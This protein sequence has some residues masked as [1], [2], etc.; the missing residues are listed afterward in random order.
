LGT[1][2]QQEIHGALDPKLP[3]FLRCVQQRRSQLETLAGTI[4][5][6]FHVAV[7]G[8]VVA[9]QPTES[10]LGDREAE[11]CIVAAAQAVHFPR[12]HGGDVDLSWP[13]EIPLD[14]DVRAPVELDADVA[15]SV[16]QAKGDALLAQCGGAGPLVVTAYVDPDGR[17]LAAG[18]ATPDPTTAQRLDC[19]SEGVRTWTFPSPGSYLGKVRFTLP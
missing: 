12:P 13:L 18:V 1:L 4:V 6:A 10:N 2:T 11:R 15:R 8:A 3:K 17:T 19:I 14:S 7:D 5:L 16:A 9:V